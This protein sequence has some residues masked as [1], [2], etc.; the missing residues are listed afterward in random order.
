M[1]AAGCLGGAT[2]TVTVTHTQTI[3][4]TQ[5]VTT[6]GS[7][8]SAK[9]CLGTQLAATFA[10]IANSSGAGQIAY[11][12]TAK[13]TSSGPCS[14]HGIPQG[15]LLGATGTTLPTHIKASGSRGKL[16][17]LPPG[18]SAIAQARFSPDV[19]GEGDSQSGS[20]Q[21]EAHTFQLTGDGGGVTEA[22]MKPPTSVCEQGT[23]NFEAF[24]YAG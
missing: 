11:A 5:T 16:I 22:P 2:K 1:T 23:L 8:S 19:A 12:L 6:T 9:P 7:V 3:T 10:E 21:P 14:L 18:A 4:S 15:T 24:G 20:C 13:N 17:V